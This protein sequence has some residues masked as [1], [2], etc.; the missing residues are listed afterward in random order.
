VKDC[1]AAGINATFIPGLMPILGYDRFM[2]TVKFCKTN[3]P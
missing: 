3:V 2:R 1:K